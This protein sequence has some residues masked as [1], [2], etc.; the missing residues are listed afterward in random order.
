M[1]VV[2]ESSK[3]IATLKP[4]LHRLGKALARQSS[5][6]SIVEAVMDN[7]E[8]KEHVYDYVRRKVSEECKSICSKN[9]SILRKPTKT[10]FLDFSWKTVSSE[11]K[12]KASLLYNIMLAVADPNSKSESAKSPAICTA[13]G[14]Q[15]K[16]RDACIS[17]IPYVIGIILKIS[18]VSK[19]VLN[20]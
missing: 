18:K 16:Q 1:T 15:L 17:L 7:K 10:A 5:N 2:Y 13:V 4:E 3:K 8:L 19:Q 14:I 6:K 20:V 11:L 9:E 12:T